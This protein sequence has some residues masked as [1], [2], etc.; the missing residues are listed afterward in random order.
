MSYGVYRQYPRRYPPRLFVG[1]LPGLV[2]AQVVSDALVLAEQPVA[3]AALTQTQLIP[4]VEQLLLLSALTEAETQS[5]SELHALATALSLSEQELLAVVHVVGVVV[6][7]LASVVELSLGM[8]SL[9][10]SDVSQVAIATP[11]GVQAAEGVALVPTHL[12]DV[13]VAAVLA[14]A[15]A[16][17]LG[18]VSDISHPV[19]SA[20]TVATELLSAPAVSDV[21]AV[22]SVSALTALLEDDEAVSLIEQLSLE[23]S[24]R[25]S[26]GMTL[27][28]ALEQAEA[29]PIIMTK[30]GVLLRLESER[31]RL[32]D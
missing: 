24:A 25:L 29:L 26:Q 27:L 16:I 2:H 23:V 32:R 8:A 3:G 6:A 21:L 10:Q 12:Q 18:L 1:S 5:L 15:L 4:L 17:E 14:L 30:I 31:V 13:V 11:V 28:E 7:E 20:L 22:E 9:T 19:A